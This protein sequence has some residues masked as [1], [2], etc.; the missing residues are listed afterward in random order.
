MSGLNDL[1]EVTL[2]IFPDDDESPSV[3]AI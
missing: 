3:D 2:R 1:D